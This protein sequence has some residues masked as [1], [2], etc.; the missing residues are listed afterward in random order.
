LVGANEVVGDTGEAFGVAVGPGVEGFDDD[1][2]AFTT[3]GDGFAFEAELL[4][5]T[6]GL[7]AS[8][9]EEFGLFGLG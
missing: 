5:E 2:V 6:D 9:P 8:R 4:G 7:A 3:D 1:G